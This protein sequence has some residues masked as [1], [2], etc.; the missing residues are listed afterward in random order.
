[1]GVAIINTRRTGGTHVFDLTRRIFGRNWIN[2][3]AVLSSDAFHYGSRVVSAEKIL[4]KISSVSFPINGE[5]KGVVITVASTNKPVFG[6]II[7][8][9][10]LSEVMKIYSK[11]T[12]I[13]NKDIVK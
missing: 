10:N 8:A 6:F 2:E 7:F 3:T 12:C 9:V 13:W 11:L 1:M 5:K 4:E